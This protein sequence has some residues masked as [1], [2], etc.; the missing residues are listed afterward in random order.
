D[1]LVGLGA[2]ADTHVRADGMGKGQHG[3][4]TSKGAGAGRAPAGLR[5][6]VM[7]SVC[8]TWNTVAVQGR[9]PPLRF[10]ALALSLSAGSVSPPSV[11]TKVTT[12]TPCSPRRTCRPSARQA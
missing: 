9:R 11:A 3:R 5:Q 4:D 12:L 1:T 7:G 2:E 6:R 10:G 8:E